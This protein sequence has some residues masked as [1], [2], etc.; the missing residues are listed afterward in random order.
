MSETPARAVDYIVIGAGSAGCVMA[1]RLSE[2]ASSSVLLLEAGGSDDH[3][4]IRMPLGFLSAMT[5]PRFAWGFMSEPEPAL[6]GR[7]LWVPRGRVLGGCSSINGM[8]Y[9]R[10]H[11]RDFDEWRELGCEGWGYSDVLPYFKRSETSWR[12][13]NFYHGASGPLQVVPIDTRKLLHEPL[14]EAARRAGYP[15]TEDI[16]GEKSEGFAR[17]EATIDGRGRRASTA[18][19][20]LSLADHRPN[21]QIELHALT[22]RVLIEHGRAVGVE[23]VQGGQIR[24]VRANREVILCGGTYNSPQ[25]LL[26]SGVGPAADLERHAI[27][28]NVDLP[29]VGR[30]LSE[31]PAVMIEFAATQPVTFL[32]ELRID[33]AAVSAARW[34]VF[35][36]G[37]F[38]TQINSA[39]GIIRTDHTLDRPD[40]Q[41]MCN[42]VRMDAGVWWPL[43]SARQRHVFSVGVV[44]LHPRSRGNV[45]LRSADP[46]DSPRIVMNTLTE[47]ADVATLRRGIREA[48][49][50]YRTPPQAELTGEEIT[51]S[52]DV[53]S[54]ADLD[55]FI[56]GTAQLCQ[57]PVGTCSMGVG[58]QAVVDSQAR[59]YG[60]QG[61]RVVDASIMPTVPGG[62]TNAAVIMAAEK[63]SDLI[64]H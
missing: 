28:T 25:L 20:Y 40:V 54:D 17:G 9:M 2:D 53:T 3:L 21:L 1:A 41:F 38:A 43:F 58:A 59:V 39:N 42:P 6:G 49:R 12:G 16:N 48:R 7:P 32:N 34:A 57:H 15:T 37:P 45:T 64:R 52:K 8:F 35:G 5:N 31:H 19:A 51:P 46:T 23:Y 11:P 60:V 50:I 29:G 10:G 30:N 44:A 13:E 18:R 24:V 33:R 4:T 63:V 27:R 26:L 56:L 62:N 22:T 61:L 36:S 55:A 14:M 47:A